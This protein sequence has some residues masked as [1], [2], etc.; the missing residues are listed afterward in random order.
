M[1]DLRFEDVAVNGIT[2]H[3]AEAGPADGRLVI[4]LHGFPE[5]WGAWLEYIKVLAAAGYHVVAHDRLSAA[6]I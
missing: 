6:T 4:L 2:L 1:E 5:Y 3:L